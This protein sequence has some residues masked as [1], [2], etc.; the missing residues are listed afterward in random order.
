MFA[1]SFSEQ[2]TKPDWSYML[3]V[4]VCSVGVTENTHT[5][6]LGLLSVHILQQGKLGKQSTDL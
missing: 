5:A 3:F 1:P 2:F 6:G 4:V